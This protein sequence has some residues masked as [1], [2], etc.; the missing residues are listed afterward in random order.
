MKYNKFRIIK[1]GAISQANLELRG[2]ILTLQSVLET[3]DPS[4]IVNR[5][6]KLGDALTKYKT[7]TDPTPTEIGRKDMLHAK[8]LQNQVI[9]KLRRGIKII[10]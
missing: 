8:A 3:N 9:Y 5:T 4:V 10:K 2:A 6:S 1:M 7:L